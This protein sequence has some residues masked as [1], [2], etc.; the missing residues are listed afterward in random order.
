V[1]YT[2]TRRDGGAAEIEAADMKIHGEKDPVVLF[3]EYDDSRTP[4]V[5][6]AF[7]PEPA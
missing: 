3:T 4:R 7:S 5:I 6:A 1:K 2:I